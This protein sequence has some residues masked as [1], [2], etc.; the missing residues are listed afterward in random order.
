MEDCLAG[1]ER[2]AC[3]R[4]VQSSIK[5]SV[6]QLIE[7]KIRAFK[8][9]PLFKITQT[10][11]VGPHESLIVF[12]G[13]K[14]HTAASI[15]SL[16]G[17]TRAFVEEAQT[18]TKRSLDMLIPTVRA[19]GSE[20]WFGWNPFSEKDPVDELFES[21]KNDPDFKCVHVTYRDNPWFPDVLRRDMERDRARDPEKYH[22]VWLGGYQKNSE[23]RVFRNWKIGDFDVPKDA[24]PYFGGDWG[25]AID[26][27]VLVC[28]WIV[29]RTL[30]IDQEAYEVGCAIDK[31]PA[32]FDQ[33]E[34]AR[35]WPITADSARPETIDYMRRHGYPHI[36]G[37]RKGPGS[38]EDGIEFLKSFDI[39]V[40]PRCTH[41]IDELT[42]YS[43]KVNK[44]TNEVLPVLDDKKNH[45]IDA[46]RYAAEQVR[47]FAGNVVYGVPE[48]EIM[49]DGLGG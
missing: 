43:Y 18:I 20:L 6:K 14:N 10:E 46:V 34:G 40:H 13:L 45:V 49:I 27:T 17:F 2:V 8:V 38:L 23:A 3:L 30:Y 25:F 39:V 11:I 7:D 44:L 5:D 19:K 47:Q 4:E 1:H 33:V 37:A 9:E 16:E 41:T 31:T 12:K 29:G 32:L 15:K 28:I 35:K 42:S 48:E 21:N 26:P 36:Q 24:R 22:H